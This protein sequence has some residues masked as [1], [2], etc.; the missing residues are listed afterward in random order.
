MLVLSGPR[1]VIFPSSIENPLE[2]LMVVCSNRANH[3]SEKRNPLEVSAGRKQVLVVCPL[4]ARQN[5]LFSFDHSIGL[6]GLILTGSEKAL[7]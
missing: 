5:F 7:F 4:L 3:L 1:E 6:L 2:K